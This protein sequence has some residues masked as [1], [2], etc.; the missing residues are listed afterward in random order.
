MMFMIDYLSLKG[1]HF[2][3]S[4]NY[5][6][7]FIEAVFVDGYSFSTRRSGFNILRMKGNNK[8]FVTLLELAKENYA[9]D[10]K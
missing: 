5:L 9:T 2:S 1:M 4:I 8:N 3:N 10:Q 7:Q 6:E